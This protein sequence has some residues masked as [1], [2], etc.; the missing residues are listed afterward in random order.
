MTVF[1]CILL[2]VYSLVNISV[3]FAFPLALL[4]NLYMVSGRQPFKMISGSVERSDSAGSPDS[5]IN[6]RTNDFCNF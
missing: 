2:E 4:V 3:S 6:S 5:L 1:S